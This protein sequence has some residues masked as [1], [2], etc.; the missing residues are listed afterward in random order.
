MKRLDEQLAFPLFDMD[1]AD[2]TKCDTSTRVKGL[3]HLVFAF[4]GLQLIVQHPEH[5]RRHV[6]QF[7]LGMVS[8]PLLAIDLLNILALEIRTDQTPF[9]RKQLF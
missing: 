4:A 2:G 5:V 6:L 7:K 1:E 3:N 8:H 9:L